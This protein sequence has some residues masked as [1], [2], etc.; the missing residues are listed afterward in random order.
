MHDFSTDGYSY[1]PLI[2]DYKKT[3]LSEIFHTELQE[4]TYVYDFGDDWTHK[5]TFEKIL[6]ETLHYP[7]LMAGKGQCPHK[8]CGGYMGV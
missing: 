1:Y 5:I 7:K 4:F 3:K 2:K 6:D 8:D